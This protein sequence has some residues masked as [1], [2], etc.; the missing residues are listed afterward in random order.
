MRLEAGLERVGSLLGT[1][2][3]C[4]TSCLGQRIMDDVRKG[5]G[6]ARA[7]N[8]RTVEVPGVPLVV[9]EITPRTEPGTGNRESST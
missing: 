5:I 8:L 1:V 7:A 2:P 6:E 3:V 9:F 4:A